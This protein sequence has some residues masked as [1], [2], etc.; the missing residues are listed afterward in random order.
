MIETTLQR[1]AQP[2]Q[3]LNETTLFK[4]VISAENRTGSAA[5]PDLLETL[6][7]FKPKRSLEERYERA[8]PNLGE[9]ISYVVADEEMNARRLS[10]EFPHLVLPDLVEMHMARLGL[11]LF[12]DPAE[13]ELAS[14]VFVTTESSRARALGQAA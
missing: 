13:D 4:R 9:I 11:S 5:A 6:R 3:P 14:P 7:T 12:S 8:Y 10:P 2:C 1:V